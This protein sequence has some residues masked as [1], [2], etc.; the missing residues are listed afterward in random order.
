MNVSGL[1]LRRTNSESQMPR[2]ILPMDAAMPTR[3]RVHRSTRAPVR[4]LVA[5]SCYLLL[6]LSGWLAVSTLA[7]LGFYVMFFLLL[8]NLTAEGFFAQLANIANRFGAADAERRAAFIG[9]VSIISGLL[10]LFVAAARSHSLINLFLLSPAA[11]KD[12][13]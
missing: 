11:R 7:T 6:R 5:D 9:Q 3:E 10:F 1:H 12:R 8:G 13:P 4:R 2:P